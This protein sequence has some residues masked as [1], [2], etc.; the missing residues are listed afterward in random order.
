MDQKA[1][2]REFFDGIARHV[3]YDTRY[4]ETT[5][6]IGYEIL[7]RNAAVLAALAGLERPGGAVLDVGCGP[8]VFTGDLLDR[9]FSV[10]GVDA[11]PAVVARA[12]QVVADH[13]HAGRAR[14]EVGDVERLDVEDGS[15]DV[16]LAVGL[17]EYLAADGPA[18]G[19]MRRVLTPGGVAIVTM[20]N[21]YSYY[22]AARALVRPLRPLL[23]RAA[24]GR[25]GGRQLLGAHRT[26][27]HTRRAFEAAAEA[28]GLRAVTADYMNF[29]PIPFNIPGRV[30]APLVRLMDAVNTNPSR[31][32]RLA[33]ACGTYIAILERAR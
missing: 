11:T 14:F 13:P 7:S 3:P 22:A 2:V 5:T 32:R 17:V 20:T 31:R 8:A 18:L 9:G 33:P 27:T 23:R 26:R 12:R 4:R 24:G 15:F 6:L 19:E 1:I 28:S 29:N 16:I 30:P 25:V 10:L 21:R